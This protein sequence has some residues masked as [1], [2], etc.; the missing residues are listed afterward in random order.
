LL[1]RGALTGADSDAARTSPA[2][3][4]RRRNTK[5]EYNISPALTRT[6]KKPGAVRPSSTKPRTVMFT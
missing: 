1:R 2:S 4:M 3:R 6:R 5:R